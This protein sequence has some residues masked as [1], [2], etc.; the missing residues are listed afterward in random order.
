MQLFL[1][2]FAGGSCY[3]FDFLK[4]NI[5]SDISFIPL[6]IP[7]RGRRFG[8]D[9]LKTKELVVQDYFDQIIER[10]NNQPYVIYG[11]SMGATMGLYVA[12][13]MEDFDDPPN[14]LVVS[15]NPGPG[16]KE[17]DGEKEKKRYL[18]NDKDFKEE[19]RELG[20]VPEEV[21]EN[22][23]LFDFFSPIMRADFEVLEKDHDSEADFVLKTSIYALMG[24]E[25]KS[26]D[27]IENWNRFTTGKF[28]FK[29]L[30]GDHFFINNH[31]EQ[32]TKII[33]TP[34]F[35]SKV[36]SLK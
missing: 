4:R 25:E 14:H 32:L 7:G 17:F 11:H 9:L 24:S 28:Q 36:V 27:K 1:L 3:S 5:S 30:N 22:K 29:I 21:L 26:K 10:R 19:L 8:E 6:E 35:D 15:G 12:K 2:H 13:K 33:E 23:D 16:I 34:L 18:M 20:G 31:S